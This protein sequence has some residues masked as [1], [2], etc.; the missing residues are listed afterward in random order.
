MRILHLIQRFWPAAG[1]AEQHMLALSRHLVQA[2]HEVTVLTSDALDFTG[3]WDPAQRRVEARQGAVDGIA[4]QRFSIAHLPA[5]PLSYHAVRR[6]LWLGS[7]VGVPLPILHRLARLTP[8]LPALR[9]WLARHGHAFDLVGAM[10][11]TF[12]PFVEAGLAAAQRHG[13]PFV[14][15]PLTHLGA[16]PT[17]ASDALSRYYTM[18]HQLDLARRSD[19]IVAQTLTEARYLRAQGVESR[20]AV[21]GPGIDPNALA[22]GNGERFRQQYGIAGPMLLTLG[23]M[24]ADKGTPDVVRA[25]QQLWRGGR[26]LALVLIGTILPDFQQFWDGLPA[27]DRR[28]IHLLGVVDE[29]TKRDALAATTLFAMPS[30]TDSFGIVYLEAWQYEKPVVAAR[31]WGVME[32]IE[33]GE[34]G[35]LVPFGDPVALARAIATL[36][37]DPVRACAMGQRGQQKAQ[38][39]TWQ[40]KGAQVEALYRTLVG[41]G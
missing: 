28:R 24:C 1:G 22:G 33:D 23:S 6:A 8:R 30:R 18:R 27:A 40:H 10:T 36:L 19:A 3:F 9:P 25:V 14:L 20:I 35:L 17:P 34:D 32:L 12:E 21:V 13:L 7:R 16:G 4:V 26:A 37:D 5:A 39:H 11:I 31:T 29:G 38:Q 41:A 15:Y 2:G